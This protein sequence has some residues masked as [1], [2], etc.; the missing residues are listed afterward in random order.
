MLGKQAGMLPQ[1]YL[2]FKRRIHS[3]NFVEC[4]GATNDIEWK[5]LDACLTVEKIMTIEAIYISKLK[6]ALNIR[7][8]NRGQNSS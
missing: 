8:E 6:P 5:K 2:L 7:D 3:L 1:E 4:C